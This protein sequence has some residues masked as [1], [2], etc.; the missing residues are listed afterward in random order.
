MCC[1]ALQTGY[2]VH[3][4]SMFVDN[5]AR[6]VS[7]EGFEYVYKISTIKYRYWTKVYTVG[8]KFRTACQTVEAGFA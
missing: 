7:S 8:Q 3:F 5:L 1:S 6:C 2:H 4:R